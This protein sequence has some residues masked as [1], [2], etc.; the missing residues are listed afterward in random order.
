MLKVKLQYFGHL[1]W[2][3]DSLEKNPDSGKDWRQEEKGRQR[4][5]WLN[6][7]T[8]VM[9][10]SLS[11]LWELVMDREAWHAAVHGVTKSQTWLSDWTELNWSPVQACLGFINMVT[12]VLQIPLFGDDFLSINLISSDSASPHLPHPAPAV[13][14]DPPHVLQLI[15]DEKSASQVCGNPEKKPH[16]MIWREMKG[17]SQ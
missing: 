14:K 5:R 7:I 11:R 4:I 13:S 12:R 17:I 9:D 8:D 15:L 1:M 6:G 2:R 10:I 3:T 16:F